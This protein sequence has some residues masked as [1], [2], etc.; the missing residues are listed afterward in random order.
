VK[1][2]P[3]LGIHVI[4]WCDSL[5]NVNRVFDRPLMREFGQRVLFQMS[6]T[7]SSTLMDSPAAS[8]LS[9]NRALYLQD[10]QERPEK[11][12]PYG[13][14]DPKWLEETLSVP[15]APAGG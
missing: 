4:V 3:P 7:D 14:P 13:L 10:E 2:G 6:P 11:F 8:K 1:D 5:V 12:R 15:R 9:R